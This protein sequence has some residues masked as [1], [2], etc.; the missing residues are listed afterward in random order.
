MN[1]SHTSLRLLFAPW[2]VLVLALAPFSASAQDGTAKLAIY[3]NACLKMLDGISHKDK[4][5]LYAAKASFDSVSVEVIDPACIEGSEAERPATML[6]CAAYADSLIQG[7]FINANLDNITI[8]RNTDDSDLMVFHHAVSPQAAVS[9]RWE[10]HDACQLM[11]AAP[12]AKALR[13]TVTN[14]ATGQRWEAKAESNGHI[15]QTAWTMGDDDSP[16][17]IRIEN[18]GDEPVSFVVALL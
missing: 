1:H 7:N 13:V 17:D 4:Y 12:Q 8:M 11:V 10:G 16:Y 5:A 14:P 6:Y 2:L 9:Y 18:T 3:R 15:A